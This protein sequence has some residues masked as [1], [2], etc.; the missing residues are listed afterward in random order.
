MLESN[1]PVGWTKCKIG[2]FLLSRKGKKP[3]YLL[4]EFKEGYLPYIL[5]DQLE[6]NPIRNYTNDKEIV[7]VNKNDVLL[8][9]DGSI[10]KSGFGFN[11]ALGSTL[12]ALTPLGGIT[13]DF[14]NYL[15]KYVNPIIRE[16]STGS[17]LQHINKDFLS[18]CEI[19]LPPLKEQTR[20]VEKLK[21]IDAKY[22]SSK[23]YVDNL[24]RQINNFKQTTLSDAFKG[25]LTKEWRK[26]EPTKTA[27]KLIKEI[28]LLRVKRFEEALES[29]KIE[30]KS[31]P[32]TFDNYDV[33]LRSDFDLFEIP[34]SWKWV[35]LRFVM[36]EDEPFC[37]G[38]IQPGTNDTKGNFLIRAGDLKNDTVDTTSLRKIPISVDLKYPRSK[39]K[40]NEILLT[41]VGANIGDVAIA[42][43]S[44]IGFN[45]A[46]A[47]AK[48]PIKD[49]NRKYVF[50]W[51]ST[52]VAN[53]WLKTESRDVARPTLN[54]EQL[55]TIPIPLPSIEEQEKIVQKIEDLFTY[56]QSLTYKY[57]RLKLWLDKLP[58]TILSKAFKGQLVKQDENDENANI[59]LE[60]IA[61]E[62]EEIVKRKAE[63][64]RD[65]PQIRKM[66]TSETKNLSGLLLK[67]FKTKSFYF[68][69]VESMFNNDSYDEL[70]IEF[71]NLIKQRK[72]ITSF[73]GKT[74]QIVYA[75]K[76]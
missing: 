59:L 10:G 68:D 38:V 75:L 54:L 26:A 71:F 34:N 37:Y 64:K 67:Q 53:Y 23:S 6:G 57:H 16:T 9:W 32:K 29:A 61:K 5:I 43:A 3:A 66:K 56:S 63:E 50:Y 15:I 18:T 25:E 52:S 41:V 55:K 51:L 21:L 27:T 69:E 65:K 62:K 24:P 33:Q 7:I 44:C 8:V 36:S 13:P 40:G 76:N 17:G 35:D 11:G 19:N 28:K 42:P 12:V 60:Q 39:I 73:D 58:Q 20:I 70:K 2:D 72:L 22:Y 14:L 1:L 48:I 31:K 46:R 45:I 30:N 47:V 74:K 4:G 49:F